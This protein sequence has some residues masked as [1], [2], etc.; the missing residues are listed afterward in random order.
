MEIGFEMGEISSKSKINTI[1]KLH[2]LLTCLC[3]QAGCQQFVTLPIAYFIIAY[4]LTEGVT[5]QYRFWLRQ[6]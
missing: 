5:I 6:I 3:Q 4:L 2:N 1:L